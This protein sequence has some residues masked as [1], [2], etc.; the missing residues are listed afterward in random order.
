MT[1]PFQSKGQHN[2]VTAVNSF[3]SLVVR[4]TCRNSMT[5]LKDL[6]RRTFVGHSC[7][8]LMCDN[9]AGSSLQNAGSCRHSCGTHFWSTF[10]KLKKCSRKFLTQIRPALKHRLPLPKWKRFVQ[11]REHRQTPA[12]QNILMLILDNPKKNRL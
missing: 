8:T 11:R 1:L 7:E 6:C 3:L 2:K 9:L 10:R 5:L 12:N 4:Y